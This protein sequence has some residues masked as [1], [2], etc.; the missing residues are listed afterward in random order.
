V[1]LN[2]HLTWWQMRKQNNTELN[3]SKHSLAESAFNFFMNVISIG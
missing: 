1:Y 3:G 2:P